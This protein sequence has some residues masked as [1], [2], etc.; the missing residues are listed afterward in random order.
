GNIALFGGMPFAHPVNEDGEAEPEQDAYT[1]QLY[2]GPFFQVTPASS[3]LRLAADD[4]ATLLRDCP[5]MLSVEQPGTFWASYPKLT[6]VSDHPE[7]LGSAGSL[8]TILQPLIFV[9]ATTPAGEDKIATPAFVLDQHSGRFRGG[10]WLI[11]A[12][13]PASEEDW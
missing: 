7:D 13:E 2:L 5:L 3:A 9:L 4:D 12:W 10:R 8:D 1:R 6:Q 11:S